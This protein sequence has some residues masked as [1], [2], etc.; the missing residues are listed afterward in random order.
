MQESTSLGTLAVICQACHYLAI[1][2]C[3]VIKACTLRYA[4][5]LRQRS[6]LSEI[7]CM[8]VRVRQ[9]RT[10]RMSMALQTLKLS[11]TRYESRS[12]RCVCINTT[13]LHRQYARIRPPVG[14]VYWICTG[15]AFLW[16]DDIGTCSGAC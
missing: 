8:S 10:Y 3:Q 1:P 6:Q 9:R 16:Y 2:F 12:Q 15:K 13:P 4:F 7:H 5:Q 14:E 11:V